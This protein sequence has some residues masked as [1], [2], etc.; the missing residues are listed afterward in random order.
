MT[1][2][3]MVIDLDR[4]TACQACVVACRVENNAPPSGPEFAHQGRD[5]S[6]IRLGSI[7]HEEAGNRPG[8]S[9]APLPCMHCENPPCVHVCPTH[10]TTIDEEGMVAQVPARCIGCRY[11][12]TACPYTVRQFNWRL[13]QWPAPLDQGR[14]PD[15][16]IRP[17]GVV[18]K[19]TFCAHRLQRARDRA[20]YEGRELEPDEYVPAC[21][22]SCPAEAMFFGD[23]DDPHSEV[24]RQA[25]SPR[26]FRLMEE[27]G[28]RPKVIYLSK[29][30]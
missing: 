4:C 29:G 19:C 3:G 24:A 6:W 27:L 13:G 16:S 8:L 15:V 25:A 21:V 17:R 10:A 26:A 20:R 2:W 7:K 9:L 1:R 12:T 5:I 23:L 11:C 14:N 28:T 22:E 30:E 18:E